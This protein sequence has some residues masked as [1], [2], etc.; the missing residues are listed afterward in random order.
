MKVLYPHPFLY[1]H[2]LS[3]SISPA[4]FAFMVWTCIHRLYLHLQGSFAL[5]VRT[6]IHQ[7]GLY[8]RHGY[9]LTLEAACII[10][11]AFTF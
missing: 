4:G 10:R 8:S 11:L 9:Y 3:D 7:G 1:L 5:N 2:S 6:C